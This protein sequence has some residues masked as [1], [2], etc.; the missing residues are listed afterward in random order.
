MP[1]DLLHPV[2]KGIKGFSAGPGY[3][4]AFVPGT[5]LEAGTCRLP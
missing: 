3:A 1:I 2:L 4:A 5:R